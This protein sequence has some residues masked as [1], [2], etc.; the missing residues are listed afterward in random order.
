V[1]NNLFPPSRIIEPRKGAAMSVQKIRHHSGLIMTLLVSFLLLLVQQDLPARSRINAFEDDPVYR[2]KK[3]G[4]GLSQTKSEDFHQFLQEAQKLYSEMDYGGAIRALM[5]AQRMAGTAMQKADVYFY[6]S[7]A[8]YATL[9]ERAR[10]DLITAIENVITYDYLREPD[11]TLC[12]SGYIE[13]FNELKASYGALK[14]LSQP[15]GADVYINRNL[16]GRTPL[17]VGAK[18]GPIDVLVKRGKIEKQ[19]RLEV[20]A[21][22]ETSPPIYDLAG[23]KRKFPIALVLAGVAIAGGAAAFALK[24]GNGND[25]KKTGSIQVNSSPTGAKI[26]LDGRDTGKVTNAT[27]ANID[28]GSHNVKLTKDGYSDIEQTVSVSAGQ[29]ASVSLTLLKDIITIIQPEA[30]ITWVKGSS[31]EIKW[32]VSAGASVQSRPIAVDPRGTGLLNQHR[33]NSLYSRTSRAIASQRRAN[34]EDLPQRGGKS[35]GRRESARAVERIQVRSEDPASRNPRLLPEGAFSPSPILTAKSRPGLQTGDIAKTLV[36]SNIKIELYKGD[37]LAETIISETENDGSHSWQVS[38]A[39]A[40]GSDYKVRASCSSDASIYGESGLITIL[41]TSEIIT[42]TQPSSQA[43][44]KKGLSYYIKW[45]SSLAGNVKIDLYKADSLIQTIVSSARN[46]GEYYWTIATSLADGSDYTILISSIETTGASGRS[47]YFALT[48]WYEFV[49]KWGSPGTG[50]SQFDFPHG[51]AIDNSNRVYVA[52]FENHRI[53]KFNSNGNFVLKWGIL[54][55]GNGQ[56]NLPKG[57][58]VDGSGNVYV[59]DSQNQRIQK[60]S[61]SGTFMTKWGSSGTGDGQFN[62][63]VGIGVDS[64]SYVY[65]AERLNNRVQ[66]F[67]ASGGFVNKWGSQGS[68]DGQFNL[69]TGIAVDNAGYVYVVDTNNSRIQKFTSNGTFVTKWGSQGAANNQFNKPRGIAID[70]GGNIFIADQVNARIL[71]YD[72]NGIFITTWGSQGSGDGQFNQPWGI[73]TDGAGNIYISDM[74]NNRIQKFRRV[75]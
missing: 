25:G 66:K 31:V 51:V 3:S 63:P 57:I 17:T 10:S 24:G 55:D 4:Y 72:S 19:D 9:S 68:G 8:Y 74:N 23:K 28:A 21:G 52:D 65:V 49:T 60:F 5:A 35:L 1:S 12:P 46:D 45:T 33:L 6:L 40:S 13:I 32:Q 14:I 36:I 43:S 59:A 44:W 73:A 64:S 53:Q 48:H 38:S 56:F 11:P 20:T 27:L 7:L 58:A 34:P 70:Q 29:T 2:A 18:A 39:L 15:P 41:E 69:P 50:N 22:R 42:I 37:T 16:T 61:S 67:T 54:G 30:G 26:Y 47:S 62:D 75:G 71:K